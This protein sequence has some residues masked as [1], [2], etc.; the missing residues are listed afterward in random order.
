MGK[1][2]RC[3]RLSRRRQLE[4]VTVP[5]RHIQVETAGHQIASLS[6]VASGAHQVHKPYRAPGEVGEGQ[7]DVALA[8]G[9]RNS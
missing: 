9:S 8:L 4:H 5:W 7:A 6:V 1:R 3:L 2:P